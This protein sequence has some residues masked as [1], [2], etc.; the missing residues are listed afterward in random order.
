M[1]VQGIAALAFADS[2][3]MVLTPKSFSSRYVYGFRP[4]DMDACFAFHV[5]KCNLEPTRANNSS[6]VPNFVAHRPPIMVAGM[7]DRLRMFLPRAPILT[8]AATAWRAIYFSLARLWAC[9]KNLE[10][11]TATTWHEVI[12][13]DTTPTWEPGEHVPFWCSPGKA[14]IGF[15]LRHGKNQ[16]LQSRLSHCLQEVKRTGM[17]HM[18]LGLMFL[19]RNLPPGTRPTW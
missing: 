11:W 19:A 14:K 7:V 5:I 4:I 12:A 6:A 3:S 17:V 8:H 9:W 1:V 16:L 18:Y 13:A 10:S 2:R 15:Q